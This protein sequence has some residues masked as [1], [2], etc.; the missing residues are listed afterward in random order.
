M[1][2]DGD[3]IA[4]PLIFFILGPSGVG[5]TTLCDHLALHGMLHINFDRPDCNGV[6]QEGLRSE[7]NAFLDDRNPQTLAE[8]IRHRVRGAARGGAT[9]T[10][11]SGIVP[12]A[13]TDAIGPRLC[14]RYLSQLS[15]T[16]FC[17]V[18]LYGSRDDCIRAFLRRE[19]GSGRG[20]GQ[21]HWDENNHYWAHK[22]QPTD[23]AEKIVLTFRNG[24]HRPLAELV[25]EILSRVVV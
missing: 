5:K 6:D 10:C 13:T 16:G 12:S 1:A 19:A 17:T 20:L 14:R 15:A 21:N 11:P 23:F 9:I 8:A 4:R 22:F 3:R 25:A 18:I 24:A 7:W 2:T